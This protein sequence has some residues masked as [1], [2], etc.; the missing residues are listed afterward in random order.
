MS[1]IARPINGEAIHD[2]D[3]GDVVVHVRFGRTVVGSHIDRHIAESDVSGDVSTSRGRT[4]IFD[5]TETQFISVS[6]SQYVIAFAVKCAKHRWRFEIIPPLSKRV[7]DFWRL[8]NFFE[9]LVIATDRNIANIIHSDARSIL[10]EK[11]TT[12]RERST[13]TT[14]HGGETTLRSLNFFGFHSIL[15]SGKASGMVAVA[16]TEQWR[17]KEIRDILDR[18]LAI[19][20]DYLV[21]RVIFEA[22]FNA[23]RH[24]EAQ[25]IQTA[26]WHLK[27][28]QRTSGDTA[29]DAKGP[30]SLV[31]WDNGKSFTSIM[32][33][34]LED[35]VKLRSTVDSDFKTSYLVEYTDMEYGSRD[36]SETVIESD[37][38][39]NM[40][41]SEE[42][43]LL[44]TLFPGVSTSGPHEDAHAYESEMSRRGMGLYTLVE[45]VCNTLGGKVAFRT[46]RYFMQISQ[47]GPHKRKSKGVDLVAKISK[48][49]K[50]VP[51][52]FG[53]MLSIDL[54]AD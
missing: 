26:S 41:T 4:Y 29:Y 32:Q 42:I 15:L 19:K 23:L 17:T 39:I 46:G 45:T 18:G 36:K 3:G 44:S 43:R 31:F 10:D 51:T 8:W 16:E 7:R 34:A 33:R 30:F 2:L 25:I 22:I 40:K 28:Y 37:I 12:F 21:S 5:F 27:L 38:D 14:Y 35:G 1:T 54:Q 47:A 9:A 49:P 48:V 6:S 50:N 53:N 52:F 11:Q 13:A 20:S 24:P